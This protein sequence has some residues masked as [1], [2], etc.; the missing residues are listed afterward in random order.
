MVSGRRTNQ[1]LS[2]AALRQSQ[3]FEDRL[4]L[5]ERQARVGDAL[6]VHGRLTGHIVL[7]SFEEMA[8]EHDAENLPRAAGD[9]L[10]DR[11]RDVGLAQMILVAVAVRTVDHYALA[12]AFRSQA[13]ADFRDVVGAVVRSS[14]GAAAENHVA[15]LVAR[16][17]ED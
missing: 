11:R 4:S 6:S 14:A 9:L 10:A 1:G 16:R 8:L 12:Q 2:A 13:A 3:L 7:P 17:L 15:R 5:L